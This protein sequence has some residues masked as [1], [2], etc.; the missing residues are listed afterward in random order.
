MCYSFCFR[1]QEVG[2]G[3]EILGLTG[4]DLNSTSGMIL[5]RP[6]RDL[7]TA[8]PR[9]KHPKYCLVPPHIA[10]EHSVKLP[11]SFEMAKSVEEFARLEPLWEKAIQFP[12]EISLEEKLQ[13]MDWPPLD[14]MQSNAQKLLGVSVEELFHKAAQA[15]DSLTYPECRLLHDGFRDLRY[16]GHKSMVV[17]PQPA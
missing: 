10:V 4:L 17:L 3:V 13:V 12:E 16:D 2:P 15:S 6:C 14:E 11:S 9:A 8:T 1:S 5:D 7:L